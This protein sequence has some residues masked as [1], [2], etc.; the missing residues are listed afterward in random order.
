M[1][2][3]TARDKP[4]APRNLPLRPM[5]DTSTACN[6]SRPYHGRQA[7]RDL[8]HNPGDSLKCDRLRL[9]SRYALAIMKAWTTPMI[10]IDLFSHAGAATILCTKDPICTC[11]YKPF[12]HVFI[13]ILL[14]A[15]KREN[16]AIV[17]ER[18]AMTSG[19]SSPLFP[20]CCRSSFDKPRQSIQE[21]PDF[22]VR[23]GRRRSLATLCHPYDL[24]RPLWKTNDR[25]S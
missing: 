24:P 4:E 3:T 23:D 22:R 19:S 8:S 10:M 12:R 18:R 1:I 20:P 17:A 2:L 7:A 16:A 25:A 15:S 13:V 11:C 5:S 9:G 21:I 14:P 6:V